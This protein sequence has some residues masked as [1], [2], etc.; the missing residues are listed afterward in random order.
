M[1]V[2]EKMKVG[3]RYCYVTDEELAYAREVH[4]RY[5][6]FLKE[7]YGGKYGSDRKNTAVSLAEFLLQEVDYHH[8]DSFMW[9]KGVLVK[10]KSGLIGLTVGWTPITPGSDDFA[11]RVKTSRGV[12]YAFHGDL[13]KA[14]IPPEVLDY[15]KSTLQNQVRN[16]VDEAFKEN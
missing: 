2:F 6:S 8:L 1:K 10:T 9:D 15:V 16:K 14:D 4:G 3:V 11:V 13:E 7:L 12:A 5:V